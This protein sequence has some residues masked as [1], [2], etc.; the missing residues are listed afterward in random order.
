MYNNKKL[1][2]QNLSWVNRAIQNGTIWTGGK[3][4]CGRMYTPEGRRRAHILYYE[5]YFTER[6]N[7]YEMI[8][9]AR[10]DRN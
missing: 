2:D 3:F 8:S 6:V 7:L 1:V 4:V 5:T 10:R 9:N